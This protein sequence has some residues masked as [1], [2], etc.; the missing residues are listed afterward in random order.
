MFYSRVS[1]VLFFSPDMFAIHGCVSNPKIGFLFFPPK[2]MAK[3][4]NNGKP[5]ENSMDLGGKNPFG[6][7]PT[8]RQS[9]GSGEW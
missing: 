6:S 5:Y 4:E 1:R 2:W 7:T 3:I 8:G 9:K